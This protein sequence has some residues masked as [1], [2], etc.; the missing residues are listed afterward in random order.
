MSDKVTIATLQQ[1]KQE[2]RKSVLLTAYDYPSGR[3]ADE[4]GVD[5]VHVGDSLGSVA[6][7]FENEI[8]VRLEHI[9]HHTAAAR[10]GVKRALLMADMPFMTFKVSPEDALRNAGRLLQEGGAEVVKMEGGRE[11]CPAIR[12]VVDAGIPVMGHV[13]VMPQSVHAQSGYSAKG[14]TAEESER[15]LA[16]ARAVEEAGCFAVVLECL[17]W[18]LARQVT[19]ALRIPAIGIGSGAEC[20][21]QIMV[22]SELVG[23]CFSRPPRF[24]KRYAEVAETIRGAICAFAADV[25]SGAY[26]DRGH[27]YLAKEK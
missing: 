24:V 14:K 9:I 12:K 5:V 15:V 26:P 1:M 10:R 25:R 3:L 13:G 27:A 8:A 20:D 21:G 18:D 22:F 23:L 4:A 16:D 17:G 7:G 6:L 19:A 11:V 2:G